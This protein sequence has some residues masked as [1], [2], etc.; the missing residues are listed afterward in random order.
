[1]REQFKEIDCADVLNELNTIRLKHVMAASEFNL[2]NLRFAILQ[3]AKGDLFRV[4]ELTAHAKIDFRDIIY[5]VSLDLN[6]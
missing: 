3:L 2:H 6:S 1:M 4:V 5:W